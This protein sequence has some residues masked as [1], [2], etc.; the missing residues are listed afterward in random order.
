MLTVS[1]LGE[2]NRRY[3]F[4]VKSVWHGLNDGGNNNFGPD[5]RTMRT[6]PDKCL[7]ILV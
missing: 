6:R 4:D 2:S 3:A 7:L 1:I 5:S